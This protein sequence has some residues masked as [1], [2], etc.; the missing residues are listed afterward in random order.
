MNCGEL[1]NAIAEMHAADLR[2]MPNEGHLSECLDCRRY[3]QQMSH[4]AAALDDLVIPRPASLQLP[5]GVMTKAA[6]G[7]HKVWILAAAIAIMT[8]AMATAAY[9]S[10]SAQDASERAGMKQV[11]FTGHGEARRVVSPQNGQL[12]REQSKPSPSNPSR[13]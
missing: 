2:S 4:L 13:N 8:I 11:E 7:G 5:Q 9:I 6:V 12:M 3:F 10:Y 1:R